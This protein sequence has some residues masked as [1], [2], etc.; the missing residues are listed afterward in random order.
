ML[1]ARIRCHPGALAGV[2]EADAGEGWREGSKTEG[3]RAAV[4]QRQL[5]LVGG[6]QGLDGD[7]LGEAVVCWVK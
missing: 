2:W 7:R 1:L 4:R 5:W 3:I 6:L